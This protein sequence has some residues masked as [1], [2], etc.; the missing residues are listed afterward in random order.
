MRGG[1][2]IGAE[3]GHIRMV[4]DGVPCGCG[5]IGCLESY[6]SGGRSSAAR[7]EEAIRDPE[8][9]AA[10]LGRVGGEPGAITGPLVTEAAQRGDTFAVARFAELGDWLGQGVATL[11]AVLDPT[12]VVVGGGVERGR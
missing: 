1:F 3:V 5:N 4:P 9:A 7:S 6:A 11:S 2:G 12:V 8:A 10:L